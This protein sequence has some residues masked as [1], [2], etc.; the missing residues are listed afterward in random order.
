MF[1]K[2]IGNISGIFQQAM[3]LRENIEQLKDELANERVEATAG[4]GMVTIVMTGKQE[5]LS[6]DIEPELINADDPEMLE[7]LLKAAVNEANRKVHEVVKQRMSTL[8][9]GLDIPGITS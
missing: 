6:I 9:G 2:G 1:P 4:G 3:N 8:T 7:T 5:V